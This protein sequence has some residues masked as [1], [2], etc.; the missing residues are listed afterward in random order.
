M[1]I[2][3]GGTNA[4]SLATTDG[5]VYYDG[6]S[7]VTTAVGSA[8]QVL[9]SNGVGVA[10]T[11]Q[12]AAGGGDFV[13]IQTQSI[14]SASAVT[15]V[16]FTIPT[17]TYENFQFKIWN[18]ATAAGDFQ[19]EISTDGGSTF[20][21]GIQ[22]TSQ[23]IQRGGTTWTAAN[24]SAS[25]TIITIMKAAVG[26]DSLGLSQSITINCYALNGNNDTTYIGG[27]TFDWMGQ[28]APAAAA[29]SPV[30]VIGNANGGETTSTPIN[31][32]RFSS[33]FATSLSGKFSL[34]G[35]MV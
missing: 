30:T 18:L 26:T 21:S 34:Y 29:T 19:M 32:I 16:D 9:T 8:T 25:A 17:S 10:P 33:S 5:V 23:Y 1:P 12:A 35:L 3:E 13:K 28:Y 20:M 11:F 27:P 7:L 6:T 22:F 4:T 24:S 31:F 15:N 14:D 2:A